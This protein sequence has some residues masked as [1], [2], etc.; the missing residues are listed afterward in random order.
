MFSQYFAESLTRE[1]SM[2]AHTNSIGL[3]RSVTPRGFELGWFVR[4]VVHGPVT[5][6][7][8]FSAALNAA[9]LAERYYAMSD[10]ELARIGLTRDRIRIELRRV[11]GPDRAG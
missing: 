6:V 3:M 2:S 7:K 4:Q 5:F 11:V 10:S 9:C 1:I 8:A